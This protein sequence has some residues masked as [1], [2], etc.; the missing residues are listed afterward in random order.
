MLIEISNLQFKSLTAFCSFPP[1]LLVVPCQ[2][3]I[4]ACVIHFR[5]RQA[6]NGD[7]D[8][9]TDL[10]QERNGSGGATFQLPFAEQ[11]DLCSDS[12]ELLK[13]LGVV[14][15]SILTVKVPNRKP[16]TR[17][18]RSLLLWQDVERALRGGVKLGRWMLPE[19]YA[20]MGRV[21]TQ[22]V[23]ISF[24]FQWM[25]HQKARA[26]G[27]HHQLFMIFWQME[28]VSYVTIYMHLWGMLG[29]TAEN[30]LLCLSLRYIWNLKFGLLNLFKG[31]VEVAAGALF[32]L[33]W[34]QFEG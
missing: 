7:A 22:V 18:R 27:A 1:L 24:L 14:L 8:P 20:I 28:F 6:A 12:G 29:Q 9:G 4:A 31:G 25:F 15:P 13:A 33:Y 10:Y 11:R 26:A 17:P 34:R 21:A 32:P 3:L 23:S 30:Q 2:W 19:V 16:T 5:C